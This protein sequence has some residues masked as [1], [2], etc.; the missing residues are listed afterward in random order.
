M[1]IRSL[2][3]AILALAI[4]L[5]VWCA[6]PSAPAAFTTLSGLAGEWDLQMDGA[7]RVHTQYVFFFPVFFFFLFL[8]FL[9][10]SF[11]V[12]YLYLF[13]SFLLIVFFFS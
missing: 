12:Y 10:S 2:L 7:T 9:H 4:A 6:A 11:Y 3:M 1:K 13:L 5:P 8:F